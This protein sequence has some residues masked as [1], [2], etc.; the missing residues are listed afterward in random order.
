MWHY[1]SRV[2]LGDFMRVGQLLWLVMLGRQ[3]GTGC[4]GG[5]GGET[6][7]VRGSPSLSDDA[8]TSW[9]ISHMCLGLSALGRQDRERKSVSLS[10]CL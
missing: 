3:R 4:E 8:A 1:L 2:D 9:A 7:K 5:G 6:V 10:L